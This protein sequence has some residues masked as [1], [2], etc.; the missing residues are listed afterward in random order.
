M[1]HSCGPAQGA[2]GT[3]TPYSHEYNTLRAVNGLRPRKKTPTWPRHPE[4]PVNELKN[5]RKFELKTSTQGGFLPTTTYTPR[6]SLGI[7]QLKAR[8]L[9]LDASKTALIAQ[10][11]PVVEGKPDLDRISEISLD[12]LARESRM[13]R[14]IFE[15]ARDVFDVMQEEWEGPRLILLGQL[16]RLAEQVIRSGA[17]V[18]NPRSFAQDTLRRRLVLRLNMT[19][20]VNYMWEAI[21]FENTEGLELIFD[22]DRPF[23]RTG[24]MRVWYTGRPC[25]RTM[26]SHINY[27]VFDS[28]WEKA[29]ADILDRADEVAAWA[30]N[31]H[32][33][34]EVF[35]VYRG[36]VRKYR[37]DFLIRLTTGDMLVLETKGRTPKRT[38]PS[39]GFWTNGCGP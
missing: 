9:E 16:V 25:A 32:L 37:P 7:D 17:I 33:G 23:L 12:R 2:Q 39:V 11:A 26:R 10:L 13:Q 35:Y 3:S 6:L 5:D 8:P 30:K 34:F 21:R 20:I 18:I 15:A 36:V 1:S 29:D 31:D 38:G 27:G 28:T 19:A 14:I 22:R 24:D 4:R